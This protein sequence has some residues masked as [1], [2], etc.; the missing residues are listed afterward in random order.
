LSAFAGGNHARSKGE[1]HAPAASVTLSEKAVVR[2]ATPP[3]KP[4]FADGWPVAPDLARPFRP[5]PNPEPRD[6][7]AP[8]AFFWSRRF[9]GSAKTLEGR[10]SSDGPN[11]CD[12]MGPG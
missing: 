11:C 5:A 2:P 4:A 7:C 12:A 8:A 6:L 9:A 3:E 1:L 10:A